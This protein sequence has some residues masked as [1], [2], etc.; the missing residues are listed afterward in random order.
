MKKRTKR[1]IFSFVLI[2]VFAGLCLY[3][4]DSDSQKF[5]K[6][7]N[8]IF[9]SGGAHFINNY[10]E[11][12]DF[13][14]ILVKGYFSYYKSKFKKRFV[15]QTEAFQTI[16]ESKILNDITLLYRTYWSEDFMKTNNESKD[17]NFEFVKH[18]GSYLINN[19]LSNKTIE[20]IKSFKDVSSDLKKAIKKEGAF[21]ETFFL[22]DTYD[23]II[24]KTQSE[25]KIKVETPNESR[26]IPVVFFS[27]II[28]NNRLSFLSFG[29]KETGGWPN[30]EKGVIYSGDYDEKSE[31]FKYSF[32]TH[33]AN[34]F[35]DMEKY[36]NLSAADLE[37][38]SKLIELIYVKNDKNRMLKQ[39]L[40]GASN[41]KRSHGHAYANFKVMHDFSKQIFKK[42]FEGNLNKWKE[43]SVKTINK[44]ALGLY[45]A[46]EEKLKKNPKV[47]EVI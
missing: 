4:F 29:T 5:F 32:L 17:Y 1:I 33:E 46:N 18:L 7:K 37:Y 10:G 2:I 20:G 40:T 14:N 34:H 36:P 47:K 43:V 26:E 23:I 45:K 15:D 35:F 44:V 41:K 31:K 19:N 21:C 38:R 16:S 6:I 39:F 24:W 8:S 28:L 30:N 22:N 42:P 12:N 9:T 13:S 3:K 25:K 11:T 27:D